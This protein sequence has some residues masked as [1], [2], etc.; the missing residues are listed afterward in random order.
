MGLKGIILSVAIGLVLFAGVVVHAIHRAPKPLGFSGLQFS[1]LTP[2]AAARTPL[3]ERGGAEI[4]AVMNDSPADRAKIKEGEVVSAIDGV[5]I[6][7][8]RQASELIRKRAAG[9]RITLTLYDITK[10]EVHPRDVSLTFDAAPPVGKKFSVRPPRT[11]ARE[12]FGQPF[13][14]AHASWSR[15]IYLGPTIRPLA[16]SGLG[17]G[18]CNAF[19]PQLW[20]VAAHAP[21]NSLFHVMAN[22]GFAHAIYKT[23]Q[24][25]GASPDAFLSDYLQTAFGA[26]VVM[27]PPE[28]RPFG[29]VVR[30]FGNNKG[31]AGFVLYR[32]TGNRIALWLA[33]VPGGDAGWAKPLVGSVALSMRCASPGAPAAVARDPS[34]PDTAVSLRCLDGQCGETDFAAGYLTVLRLGY[35]HNLK[36]D[37]FLVHPRKDFW[38]NGAEGPGFYHQIGGE[39]EKL[40]PGRIN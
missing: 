26:P 28:K 30:D 14:V 23:A 21:D 32:V 3:L 10:G 37:M 18:Q 1:P 39:N 12:V 8:A 13:P 33:A 16:L 36:G 35:V 6:R 17:A 25:N 5:T 31:G 24:L 2:A 19:A 20:R 15:R 7:S 34:L 40:L 38:Q 22:E 11:L 29:F 4:A 9:D 27:T